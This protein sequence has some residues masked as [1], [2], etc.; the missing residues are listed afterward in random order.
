MFYEAIS[1]NRTRA[2]TGLEFNIFAKF[3]PNGDRYVIGAH[4]IFEEEKERKEEGRTRGGEG[5]RKGR[6]E[7][8][9]REK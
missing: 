2:R 5:G 9:G 7:E 3:V 4:Y 6:R 8:D 1:S